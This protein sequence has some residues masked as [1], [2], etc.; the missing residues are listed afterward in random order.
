[1]DFFSPREKGGG[2]FKLLCIS[3]LGTSPFDEKTITLS[4]FFESLFQL[5]FRDFLLRQ[6]I[7]FAAIIFA[8]IP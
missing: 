7:G 8:D 6:V 4:C 1:M 3:K 5:I 2:T